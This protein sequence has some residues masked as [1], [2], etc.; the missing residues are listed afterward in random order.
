MNL[1][2]LE[3]YLPVGAIKYIEQ[4][5]KGER[6]LIKIKNPRKS[7]LGDYRYLR[8]N[9]THQ[10]TM[11]NELSPEAFFFV[12]THE[13]AHLKVQ[14]NYSDKVKSHGKEWKRIFGNLLLESIEVYSVELRSLI[15]HHS[16]SPKA[17]VGADIDLYKK[18]F[19]NE[20]DLQ[21]LIENLNP[22]QRFRLGKRIFKKGEK[23]KIRYICTEIKSGRR[24]LVRGQAVADEIYEE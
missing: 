16:R 14:N 21:N 18:L 2:K 24:Y 20:D 6:I 5:L 11:N 23:R 3:K 1:S 8:E 13:I 19:M 9:G 10:I 22:G 7:K 15:V 12:F 17:S 4:W